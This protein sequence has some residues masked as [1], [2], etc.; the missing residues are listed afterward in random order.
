[1]LPQTQPVN[2]NV[3]SCAKRPHLLIIPGNL[4]MRITFDGTNDHI[5]VY[6]YT[7]SL[8]DSGNNEIGIVGGNS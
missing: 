7:G 5:R 6:G 2:S 8:L 3:G 1:M 4:A